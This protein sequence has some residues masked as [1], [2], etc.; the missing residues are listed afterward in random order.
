MKR[1]QTDKP[2]AYIDI[3]TTGLNISSD[4]IVELT[5]LKVHPDGNEELMT[6]RVN[7]EIPI[8]AA[9]TRIHGIAAKD[10][11]SKPKFAQCAA[12]IRDFLDGCDIGGFAVKRFDLP[13]LEAE[14]KRVGIA[15]SRRGRRV[16]DVQ[17]IYHRLE[18]HDL[19]AAYKKYCGKELQNNH[20]SEVDVRATRE[21]LER[22]LDTNPE[23][24]Q[25]A[26][27]LHCFCNPEEADWVDSEGKLIWGEKDEA[28]LDFG[29]YRGKSI[30]DV[31][32]SDPGYLKWMAGGDFS[33][34]VKEISTKALRG[35]FPRRIRKKDDPE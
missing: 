12:G 14:F 35:E 1:L 24:P 17:T 34:E 18:P 26:N 20:S 23:L 32:K 30:I 25:D 16:L 8:P 33:R 22:Q 3:E 21:V 2:I 31:A 9:A 15:F 29:R 19:A 6:F 5:M 10:V 27:G 13:L 28:V 7:P 4:R 11:A